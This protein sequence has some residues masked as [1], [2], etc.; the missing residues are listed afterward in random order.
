MNV[1]LSRRA[2][3]AAGGGL[4]MAFS[5]RAEEPA[6]PG[7]PKETPLLDAWIRVAPD[8]R[9]TVF[10]GKVEMGQGLKTALLQV[11]AEQ[12]DVAPDRIELVTADTARTA[13]EGFTAG[14]HS[15]Q[16]SGTAI[17]NAA[18]QVRALLRDAA[19][20][21]L[22]V[23]A[24]TLSTTGAV[25]KALD[26]RTLEYGALAAKLNLHVQAQPDNPLKDPGSYRLIG[27]SMPRVDIPA[28]LTGG[29]AYVQDLR[30]PG[31]LH[32]RAI[33]QPSVGAKLLDFDTAPVERMQ[34]VVR[35]VREASYLVVVAKG[36]WQ[37]IKAMRAL[38]T[39][40]KW[41]ETATLPDE[42]TVLE[43]LRALP[44][45]DI[46]VLNWSA[47]A[48]APAKRLQARYT[49]PYMMH[50]AIGPSC[51]VAW[52]ADGQ[53]TVWTLSRGVYPLRA[54]L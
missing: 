29:A 1:A 38:A 52:F 25:V 39:E 10:T 18:A 11:A 47:P 16:D 20:Q 35:V 7:S 54:A 21:E 22:G 26:G 45:K 6:R 28:K 17:L 2:L 49:R 46:S 9:I 34:G 3:L 5:L 4:V 32:A 41:Q 8:G 42:A 31:L 19:A 33:R 23:A 44:A 27:A 51:A 50:G 15:M 43:K 40:A 36:E 53:M 24:E 37:A 12:L 48:G 13:N 14:S 30:L